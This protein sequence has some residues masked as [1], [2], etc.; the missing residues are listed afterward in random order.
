MYWCVD[1]TYPTI[2]GAD[3]AIMRGVTDGT[4]LTLDPGALP[5]DAFVRLYAWNSYIPGALDPGGLSFDPSTTFDTASGTM[6]P[7]EADVDVYGGEGEDAPF[8]FIV[9]GRFNGFGYDPMDWIVVLTAVTA[10]HDFDLPFHWQ[11]Y[12]VG[13]VGDLA[14]PAN[15]GYT[16]DRH[17]LAIEIAIG[18]TATG[19]DLTIPAPM[20]PLIAD[21][22][23][24]GFAYAVAYTTFAV[25]GAGY[26]TWP[27][28]DAQTST[29]PEAVFVHAS[30]FDNNLPTGVFIGAPLQIRR[31]DGLGYSSGPAAIRPSRGDPSGL[32][33]GRTP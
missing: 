12:G 6:T 18:K 3:A 5:D 25:A 2:L 32:T 9:Y 16:N 8:D 15:S 21:A 10:D 20:T 1:V 7:T 28:A 11:R 4:P 14:P 24:D 30:A 23:A 27:L 19:G 26:G 29:S 33:I 22:D 13:H 31:T 17:V